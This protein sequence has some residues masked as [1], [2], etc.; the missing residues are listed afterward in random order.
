MNLYAW[1]TVP[2]EMT[3]PF[4]LTLNVARSGVSDVAASTAVN[5]TGLMTAPAPGVR[6]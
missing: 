2:M 4:S 3:L 6:R 5:C 1:P